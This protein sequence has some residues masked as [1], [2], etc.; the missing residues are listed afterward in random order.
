M[1]SDHESLITQAG[2]GDEEAIG[3]LVNRHLPA[4]RAY[5]R[6]RMGPRI[7]RWETESDIAQS[8]C[9]EALENLGHFRYRGEARFRQWLF[10]VAIRKLVEKDRYLRAARRNTDL[11][12]TNALHST[13]DQEGVAREVCR[14]LGTPSEHAIGRET[15][16]RIERALDG[17]SEAA[18]EVFLLSRLAGLSNPEIAKLT[19]KKVSTV[20]SLLG[21]TVARL[22]EIL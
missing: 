4:L 5:I 9:R 21:R 19:G 2:Q 8:V 1:A 12:E 16:E 7:R 6:L 20:C 22:S 15:E 10:T 18:R 3:A 14:A 13:P 17:M 11:L